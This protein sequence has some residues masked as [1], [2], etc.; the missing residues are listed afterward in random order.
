MNTGQ[1]SFKWQNHLGI[2]MSMLL[3]HL[4]D[5]WYPGFIDDNLF[6]I[7]ISIF[8]ITGIDFKLCLYSKKD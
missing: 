8:V 1:W 7:A 3:T 6:V 5:K 4:V 2:L